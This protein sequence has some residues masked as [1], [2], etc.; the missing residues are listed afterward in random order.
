M[1]CPSYVCSTCALG[2]YAANESCSYIN[3]KLQLNLDKHGVFDKT[4]NVIV[5]II[6]SFG[7][8]QIY[9]TVWYVILTISIVDK[10]YEVY[11][12]GMLHLS[13]ICPI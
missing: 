3:S 10:K 5:G 2:C 11:H 8:V 1:E 13:S 9:T 6:L 7:C 12:V 4:K